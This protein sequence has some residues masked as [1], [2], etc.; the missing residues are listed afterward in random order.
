MGIID[1]L[2]RQ[3]GKSSGLLGRIMVKIMNSMDS[4]LNKW[5]VKKILSR[6]KKQILFWEA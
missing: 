1:T 4:G 2:V 3:S 5:I 6:K